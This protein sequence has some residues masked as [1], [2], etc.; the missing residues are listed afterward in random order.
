MMAETIRFDDITI[1]A[2][3]ITLTAE[4]MSLSAVVPRKETGG[5]AGIEAVRDMSTRPDTR[6]LEQG[7]GRWL[8][9]ADSF[10]PFELDVP[11]TWEP[12]LE[13]GSEWFV[14]GYNDTE[15]TADRYE[16]RLGL[17]RIEP[18]RLDVE[19]PA[20]AITGGDGEFTFSTR[21]ETYDAV[22]SNIGV[23]TT[24]GQDTGRSWN[25]RLKEL[26][27]QQAA[28]WASRL[29]RTR[30]IVERPV[31]GD[32]SQI[33]DR[34]GGGQS[35]IVTTPERSTTPS[36]VY[37][38]SQLRLTDENATGQWSADIELKPLDITDPDPP[39]VYQARGGEPYQIDIS[40]D[41]FLQV[42]LSGAAGDTPLV[43]PGVIVGER[44]LGGRV[45]ARINVSGLS[46]TWNLWVPDG[47]ESL[48]DAGIGGAS[49]QSGGAAAVLED[50]SD[51]IAI[52]H[53]GGGPGVTDTAAGEG[54]GGGGAS[55]RAEGGEAYDDSGNR[56]PDNDGANGEGDILGGGDGG[57]AGGSPE[58][59]EQLELDLDGSDGTASAP[60]EHIVD[61]EVFDGVSE[62]REPV[63]TVIRII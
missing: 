50:G 19:M 20:G 32:R 16:L 18:K 14:T 21:D 54:F 51:V 42:T 58:A 33:V 7:R 15:R 37:A 5:V 9:A 26:T 30:A 60:S 10:E 49:G 11:E 38:V 27:S 40:D 34:T 3:S 44:G 22:S 59:N 35:V 41:E 63:A 55:S 31:K 17:Q 12:V 2:T 45:R 57:D 53:G 46:G 47:R 62:T 6:E 23:T 13:D 1:Q 24:A 43:T 4:T 39:E 48:W 28:W 25:V 52:A 8:T 56:L 61:A 29:G 36:D